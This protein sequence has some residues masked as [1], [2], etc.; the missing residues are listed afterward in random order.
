MKRHSLSTLREW[1]PMVGGGV[2]A[3]WIGCLVVVSLMPQKH[4]DATTQ[5]APLLP[6]DTCLVMPDGLRFCDEVSAPAPEARS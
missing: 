3:A 4:E 6:S 2:F 5:P 1:L